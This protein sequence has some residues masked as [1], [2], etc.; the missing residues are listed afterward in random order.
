M[1]AVDHV[2]AVASGCHIF[3]GCG[4]PAPTLGDFIFNPIFSIGPWHVTK[5]ELLMVIVVVA[6]LTFFWFAFHSPKLVPRGAQNIGELGVLFVRD[7]ILRPMIGKRGDGYLPFLCS[8]FFFIWIMNLLEIIPVAQFPVPAHIGFVWILVALV[9]LTY[10]S[11]GIRVKGPLGFFKGMIPSGVPWWILWL[12]APIIWFS[13]ILVRPFTLGV[14]LFANMFAGHLLLLVFY[15][16]TWY[17]ASASFGLVYAAGSLAMVIIL[18][19]FEMLIQFLQ[20]FIFTI[21][22]AFY[23]GD[24]MQSAH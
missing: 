7:Q 12:L 15:L 16:A 1:S 14:R 9:W 20:A 23:I 18:T 19:G 3:S 2:T 21:L 13:D 24:S 17:F 6:I 11:V 10:M 4:Y 5:P 22:T 8:L